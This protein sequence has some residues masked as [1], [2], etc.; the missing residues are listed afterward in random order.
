MALDG[1]RSEGDVQTL[2]HGQRGLNELREPYFRPGAMVL[3]LPMITL[4]FL[5]KIIFILNFPSSPLVKLSMIL[6]N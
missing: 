2:L 6:P 5:R 4:N 3:L 1:R